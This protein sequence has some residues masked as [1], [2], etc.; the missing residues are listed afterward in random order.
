MIVWAEDN[1]IKKAADYDYSIPSRNGVEWKDDFKFVQKLDRILSDDGL[2]EN[3]QK[4]TTNEMKICNRLYKFY[5]Q[6]YKGRLVATNIGE[7]SD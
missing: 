5:S 4:L 7:N 6:C 3:Q 2:P 1:K